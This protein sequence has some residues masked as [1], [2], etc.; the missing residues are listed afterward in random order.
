MTTP[1]LDRTIIDVIEINSV[2][3]DLE[4]I[5]KALC[6]VGNITLGSEI[7]R[8]TRKIQISTRSIRD[9][10]NDVM[11]EASGKKRVKI[12]EK[13]VLSALRSEV[14]KE[15]TDATWESK[16]IPFIPNQEPVKVSV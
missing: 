1:K 11:E 15:T 9:H 4:E 6:R 8:I 5:A 10:R 13:A 3:Y 12:D 16:L 7:G 2:A 14:P